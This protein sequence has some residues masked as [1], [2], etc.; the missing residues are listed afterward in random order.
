MCIGALCHVSGGNINI[1]LFHRVSKVGD[2]WK[3]TSTDLALEGLSDRASK[4]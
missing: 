1:E 2:T 4:P 3:D